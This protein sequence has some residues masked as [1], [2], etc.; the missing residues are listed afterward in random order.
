[1]SE[2]VVKLTNDYESETSFDEGIDV[3]LDSHL[4]PL[5]HDCTSSEVISLSD[6]SN[7]E[8]YMRI[9]FR[10]EIFHLIHYKPFYQM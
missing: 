1:M 3:S 5:V 10:K 6:D 9:P 4:P 8:R 7:S 2:S